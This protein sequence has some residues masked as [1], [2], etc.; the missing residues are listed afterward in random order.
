V[1]GVGYIEGNNDSIHAGSLF[2]DDSAEG[3]CGKQNLSMEP[4]T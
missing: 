3:R 1:A 4:I 2:Y